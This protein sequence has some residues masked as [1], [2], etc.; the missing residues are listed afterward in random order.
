M[1]C[2]SSAG[3]TRRSRASPAR[4]A[5]SP[6]RAA[7]ASYAAAVRLQP[8]YLDAL[9]NLADMLRHLNRQGEAIAYL[10]RFLA[11][12][13]TDAEA[14]TLLGRALLEAGQVDV[15]VEAFEQAIALDPELV[16]PYF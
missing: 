6:T 15:A 13:P 5:C 10:Q 7:S 12:K 14:H 1:C 3:M 9:Y 11:I 16:D 8:D 2:R 4:C